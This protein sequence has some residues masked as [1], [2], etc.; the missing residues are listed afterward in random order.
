MIKKWNIRYSLTIVQSQVQVSSFLSTEGIHTVGR[1][2][3]HALDL[4]LGSY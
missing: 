2:T 1:Q 4:P 3:L